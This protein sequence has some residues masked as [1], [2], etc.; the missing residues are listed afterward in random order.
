MAKITFQAKKIGTNRVGRCLVKKTA[1]YT[2]ISGTNR[3]GSNTIKI[4]IQYKHLLEEKGVTAN[5]VTL[6]NL[7]VSTRNQSIKTLEEE[8]LVPSKKFI[9][10]S[11][12]TMAA[13]GV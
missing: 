5:L 2:I 13:F 12:N 8:I 11:L 3:T 7:D 10:V 1:M 9:F 4:A 6:E